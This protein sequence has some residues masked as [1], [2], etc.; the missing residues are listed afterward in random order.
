MLALLGALAAGAL[1]TLAPCVLPMLPVVVGGAATGGGRRRAVVVTAA[2]GVSVI[3]FTLLL[4][5]T[6]ALLAIPAVVWSA[7]SGGVLVGLGLVMVFPTWWARIAMHSRLSGSSADALAAAGR[8]EGIAGDVLTGAA[9]GPVF[10]SAAR[11]T[12]M[13]WSPCSRRASGA[14][15]RCSAPTPWAC[16]RRCCSWRWPDGD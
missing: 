6:T 8:R 16:R 9:L 5:A 11:C 1:T 15:W 2:L 3:V 10:S 14:V 4:K 7:L 13:S 12:P